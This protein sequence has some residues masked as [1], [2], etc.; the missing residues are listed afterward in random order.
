MRIDLA[1]Q[2]FQLQLFLFLFRFHDI[3]YITHVL[4]QHIIIVNH[5][6]F[7]FPVIRVRIDIRLQVPFIHLPHGRIQNFHRLQKPV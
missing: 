1:H 4:H 5:H 7:N 3:I 6:A 2:H